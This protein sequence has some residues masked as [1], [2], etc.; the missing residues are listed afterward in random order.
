M[1][2]RFC[3][4]GSICTL[5]PVSVTAREWMANHIEAEPYMWMGPSL[6]VEAR[7]VAA[8]VD[9]MVADGLSVE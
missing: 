9:G 4:H 5:T 2:V 6:C 1:D 7:Y 3:N 8:I